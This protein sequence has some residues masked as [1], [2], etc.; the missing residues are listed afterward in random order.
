V[1]KGYRRTKHQ[2]LIRP[3]TVEDA[4]L[5]AVQ[6]VVDDS[7]SSFSYYNTNLA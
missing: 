3:F 7:I 5:D 2:K 4:L 1:L 6:P